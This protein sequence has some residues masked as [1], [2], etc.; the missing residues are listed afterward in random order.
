MDVKRLAEADIVIKTKVL[1]LLI[2][3]VIYKKFDLIFIIVKAI[4]RYIEVGL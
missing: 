1:F 4:R 3:I 2:K